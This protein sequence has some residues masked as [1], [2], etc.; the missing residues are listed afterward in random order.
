MLFAMAEMSCEDGL[1][2]Q[3]HPGV[4]RNHSTAV[5]EAYG[6]DKG[7]DIPDPDRVHPGPAPDAGPLRHRSAASG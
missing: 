7:Y 5:F 2:M 4:L 6:L 1:V 3:I